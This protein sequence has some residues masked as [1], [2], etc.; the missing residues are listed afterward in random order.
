M[1]T[2]D[3]ETALKKAKELRHPDYGDGS[4]MVRK[5]QNAV[6]KA[7]RSANTPTKALLKSFRNRALE[8][9]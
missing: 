4:D 1:S 3:Y 6:K 9:R 7:K 5:L 2:I 8:G